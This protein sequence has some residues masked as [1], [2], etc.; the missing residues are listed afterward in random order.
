MSQNKCICCKEVFSD[1]NVY[2]AAGW[3]EI[4]ITQMCE[5]CFDEATL[6]EEDEDETNEV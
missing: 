5:L 1:K 6:I 3:R 2:S 4:H